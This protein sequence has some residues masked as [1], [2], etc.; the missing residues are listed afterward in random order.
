MYHHPTQCVRY[1]LWGRN[2]NQVVL[3]LRLRKTWINKFLNFEQNS[4][5]TLFR[6]FTLNSCTS[7]IS[8][9]IL[10]LQLNF[11]VISYIFHIHLTQTWIGTSLH[12]HVGF[13]LRAE[14][15]KR[16]DIV[17]RS[18]SRVVEN[19]HFPLTCGESFIGRRPWSPMAT[20]HRTVDE[21]IHKVWSVI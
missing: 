6:L 3:H 21:Y 7:N 12:K 20:A 10:H 14:A 11:L 15:L 19:S 1:F 5:N 2:G 8:K 4:K 13:N 9:F 17:T 18:P 16:I